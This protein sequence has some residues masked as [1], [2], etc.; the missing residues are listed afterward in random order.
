M[1]YAE[2][3]VNSPA[4][5][6]RSFSYSVPADMDIVLGQAVRVPFGSRVME[7]VVV[8]LPEFPAVEQTRD[9]E[10]VIP[11]VPPLSLTYLALARWIADYY[12]APLFQ[13]VALMLPP[14]FERK[15]LT[16]VAATDKSQ[17]IDPT[18]LNDDQL[19]VLGLSRTSGKVALKHLVKEL[20]EKRAESAV[21]QL[22]RRGLVSKSYQLA[23]ARVR[24]RTQTWLTLNEPA[25]ASG[26]GSTI[27]VRGGKRQAAVLDLLRSH[28][29]PVPWPVL[30]Q[31]TGCTKALV[32]SLIDKG[33]VVSTESAW[34]RDPLSGRGARPTTPLRLTAS[35][36]SALQA[37][38]SSMC[39][40]RH[41]GPVFLLHGVTASGKTEVYL[42]ALAD[43]IRQGKRGIVLVPE[44]S[45]TPQ[46]IERFAARFPNQVAVLHSHL[47]LGEQFDEW[48]RIRT[49][50]FDVVIGARSALFAP[51][52]NLGLIIVDEEHEWTYKQQDK[53]PRYHARDVAIKLAQLSGATVVLGSAT[54]GVESYFRATRGDYRLLSLPERVTPVENA[55]LPP[56]RVVDIRGEL[57]SGNSELFSQT[58]SQAVSDAVASGEQVI[59]FLNRRGASTFVQCRKCGFVIRC[60]RCDVS[61]TYHSVSDNLVCHL[62]NYRTRAPA[63]C[64]RCHNPG[65][66]FLGAGTQKLEEETT[67]A[68]AGA[69][70]LR[71]DSDSTKGRD[72]H[73]KILNALQTYSADILV[74]TQMI[75][76]GLDLPLVTV[77]GVIN[78]DT[79][80][81]LPDFRAA[82]RTFQLLSQV[83]GRAGRGPRGG[84]VIFQTYNPGHFAI[85]AAAKHDYRLFYDR[86]ITY[87]R[88]LNYPPFSQLASLIYAHTNDNYCRSEAERLKRQMETDSQARGIAGLSII[89]P[90]PAFIHRLRGRYRWQVV[91]R[92]NA[93]SDFLSEVPLPRGWTVDIDPM[94]LV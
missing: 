28:P 35:Q 63:V 26:E 48:Q 94:G 64:P 62:C 47:S 66:K 29:G 79:G 57:K 46:T 61:L 19:L 65:I 27:P 30:R 53:A 23:A 81:N 8:D 39:Q 40:A 10:A 21:S 18:T 41:P 80:L 1:R 9:V 14:G 4:A 88:Q 42:Q 60:R 45:L 3:A 2:V 49:G 22:V 78:A 5:Q 50:E 24:A 44:I 84:E 34:V 7:G 17:D 54:P 32:N 38:T 6:R 58:L 43:A 93:L 90:A 89:G 74:G 75:A 87:R 77:V 11:E 70:V 20:G 59:L 15:S 72:S 73:Q 82:E 69:R 85:L 56:V 25:E 51:Q 68:F 37:I 33:L 76:K 86:E 91:V 83:A 67:R 12:L 71:W 13:C 92:G 36:A 52:P 31:A 55:P 16:F